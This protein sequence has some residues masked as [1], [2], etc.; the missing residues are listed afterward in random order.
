M[1]VVKDK[2]NKLQEKAVAHA[3]KV[4]RE[5]TSAEHKV[6]TTPLVETPSEGT[7]PEAPPFGGGELVGLII[8]PSPKEI[9]ALTGYDE[10]GFSNSRSYGCSLYLPLQKY[11]S[12]LVES[13]DAVDRMVGRACMGDKFM[14]KRRTTAPFTEAEEAVYREA[15][16]VG[17]GLLE[18][19]A[20]GPIVFPQV[21]VMGHLGFDTLPGHY[22]PSCGFRRDNVLKEF[23]T[24][25]ENP[26]RWLYRTRVEMAE[27]KQR[28]DAGIAKP[29]PGYES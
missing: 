20:V 27:L 1:S 16:K 23:K 18:R 10:D 3:E 2:V 19:G 5:V 14:V 25:M 28:I 12:R 4:A 17:E 26:E 11:C 24:F 15:H 29:V 22:I 9:Q 7:A 6:D 21:S 8:N 13:T